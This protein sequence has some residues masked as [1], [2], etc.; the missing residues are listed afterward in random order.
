MNRKF[1]LILFTALFSLQSAQ[2]QVKNEDDD[3]VLENPYM[4][5][6]DELYSTGH[7]DTASDRRYYIQ[8]LNE[9]TIQENRLQIP[10]AKQNRNISIMDQSLIR[11]LPV[12]SVNELLT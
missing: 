5:E 10:F 2:A 12:K 7:A 1:T 9:I 4:G 11:T 8:P 6:D 3:D